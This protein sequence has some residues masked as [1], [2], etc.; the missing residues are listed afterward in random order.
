MYR[1]TEVMVM[2]RRDDNDIRM[3][4]VIARM[5]RATE[6]RSWGRGRDGEVGDNG[7]EF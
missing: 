6:N 3:M 4:I 2:A 1:D 5:A 7:V